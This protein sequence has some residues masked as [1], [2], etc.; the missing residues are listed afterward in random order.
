VIDL[1]SGEL[2]PDTRRAGRLPLA[3]APGGRLLA[4]MPSRTREPPVLQAVE[5]GAPARILSSATGAAVETP[6]V[7]Y[8]AFD[9]AGGLLVSVE[10]SPPRIKLWDVAAGR[11]A[12]EQTAPFDVV[13]AAFRPDGRRLAV[14]GRKGVALFDLPDRVLDTVG[15]VAEPAVEAMAAPPDHR[16]LWV[17]GRDTRGSGPTVPARV[18]SQDLGPGG[19][20]VPRE[21]L[22]LSPHRGLLPFA[23]W[24]PAGRTAVFAQRGAGSPDLISPAT[25]PRWDVCARSLKAT[26]FAPDGRIWVLD[27]DC[28]LKAALPGAAP[29]VAPIQ[30][31]WRNDPEWA[32]K[33]LQLRSLTAGRRWVF[34]GRRDGM[35]VR[36]DAATGSATEW[37]LLTTPADGLAVSPDGTRLLVG[38]EDGEVRLVDIETGAATVV[39]D[40]HRADVPAVAFGRHFFVTGSA[41]RRVR[42]WT[43]DGRPL[44]TLRMQGPVRKV[45]LSDDERSLLVLVEGERAVR[46]WRLGDLFQEWRAHG[47]GGDLPPV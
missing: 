46:R 45:L 14:A 35:V 5:P 22:E 12:A 9:P 38:G 37:P 16:E 42:L 26:C 4:Y 25:G 30:T 1:E 28:L 27:K 2:I 18:Y 11:L 44:A 43:L 6:D 47:L 19:S 33:G 36:V 32:A 31:V 20:P 40:A 39:P 8:L 17:T 3:V 23:E 41:D 15:V 10:I 13:R 34:V 29:Y 21:V 7:E 24:W